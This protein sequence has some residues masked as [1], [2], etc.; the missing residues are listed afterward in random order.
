MN[1]AVFYTCSACT[2][3]II[4]N[5]C[6]IIYNRNCLFGTT[7]FALFACDTSVFAILS[8]NRAFFFVV[9]KYGTFIIF[10]NKFNNSFRAGVNT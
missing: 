1:R 6:K 2:T 10:G 5:C 8:C 3:F 4:V 7:E 9:A